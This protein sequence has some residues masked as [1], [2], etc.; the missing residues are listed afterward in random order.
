[1]AVTAFAAEDEPP[2]AEPD[3]REAIAA[4]GAAGESIPI[5]ESAVAVPKI[6][7]TTADGKGLSLEKAD[8]YVPAQITITDTDGAA[9]SDAVNLKVRGNSTAMAHVTKKSFNFKFAKKKNVL[10]MGGGKKWALLANC[11]DPTLLRNY[12]VFDLAHELGLEYTS[13]QRFVEVW[14]D[15][16]YRGCY[17]LYE[18][19]QE[20]KD[21]VDIDIESND[22]MKDFLLEYEASRT[23]DGVSYITAGG[24]RFALSD[25]D[26]PTDE[27]TAYAQ[28]IMQDIAEPLRTGDEAAIREKLDI[29]SFAKFYLLNEYAKTG[30]FGLSSVFFYYKDGMLYAGPPWDYDLALGNLNGELNSASAKAGSVSDGIMQSDKHFYRYLV[31]KK[32]FDREVKQVYADHYDYFE[33]IAKDG[34]VLDSMRDENSAVIAR[35]FTVW[36]PGRWWLNYQRPPLRGYDAN[37]Q[38]LKTWCGERN[39]WL[40]NY[41]G[42]YR[43]D[44]VLGDADDSGEIEIVDA[45]LVQRVLA[46]VVEDVDGRIALRSALSPDSPE[47]SDATAIQR[48]MAEMD[49]LYGLGEKRSRMAFDQ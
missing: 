46:E 25:P 2:Y 22:G 41:Y 36:D 45:T 15:G 32:W 47:I 7:I 40:T 6:E 18:P 9:L 49:D 28:A 44:Y 24:M 26:E 31:G 12:L 4:T 48:Y 38:L 27:Q 29:A 21:R 3:V 13:E 17:T 42:L 5:G 19:V 43:Y 23:E 10:G 34:G 11:F 20:G 30:D 33:N 14:L 37:Y 16:S 1:M 8:G 35:N 39:D